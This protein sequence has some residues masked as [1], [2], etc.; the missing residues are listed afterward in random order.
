MI[1]G[2]PDVVE[3]TQ[4]AI[5]RSAEAIFHPRDQ[6]L[7]DQAEKTKGHISLEA[8]CDEYARLLNEKLHPVRTFFGAHIFEVARERDPRVGRGSVALAE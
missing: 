4:R 7:W 1:F 6:V 2:K 5:E 8:I 3:E